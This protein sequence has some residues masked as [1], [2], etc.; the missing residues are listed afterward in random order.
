M[1]KLR[2][3]C[4]LLLAAAPPAWARAPIILLWMPPETFSDWKTVAGHLERAPRLKLMVGLTAEML[5]PRAEAALKAPVEQG[6]LE[7]VMRIKGD[8]LLPATIDNQISPRPQD[9]VNRLTLCREK[10]RLLFG[11]PPAGFA[12]GAGA[13]GAKMLPLLKAMN[14]PWAAAG[15]YSDDASPW[16]GTLPAFIPFKPVGA[17]DRDPAL[18]ELSSRPEGPSAAYV[19]DEAD[20]LVPPGAMLRLLSALAEQQGSFEWATASEALRL[21]GQSAP[22][23]EDVS[24]WPAWADTALW[25]AEPAQQKAWELYG[26]TAEA[27]KRYQNSGSADLKALDLA[28]QELY[29]AQANR[30]YRLLSAQGKPADDAERELRGKLMNVYRRMHQTP[31]DELYTSLTTAKP[32]RGQTG[33]RPIDPAEQVSTAVRSTSGPGW[34]EFVNPA[35]TL[36]R[37]PEGSTETFKLKGL[38]LEW[39]EQSLVFIYKLGR[40]ETTGLGRLVL[41]AYIDIN[42]VP[43]AGSSS[44]LEGRGAFTQGKDAWEYALT[45]SA[46]GAVLYRSLPGGRPAVAAQMRATPDPAK[47]EVRVELLRTQLKG[48][49]LR[50]GFVAAAFTPGTPP[51]LRSLLAPLEIQK[52]SAAGAAAPRL[53]AV[54]TTP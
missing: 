18:S 10:F 41:D 26:E 6:R 13:L 48:N 50:W 43:G 3:A 14:L 54:R 20:G 12:P 28:T 22:E 44:L 27:L 33:P 39:D 45:A 2:L 4:F 8:P 1:S 53:P 40:V 17:A 7:L 35:G 31:P 37:S 15:P 34:L 30:Y 38:R 5:G 46:G 24:A 11:G 29:A 23:P 21:Q 25:N 42:H 16:A 36:A 47:Q 9:L 52:A 51:A 19:V 32:D 49:P